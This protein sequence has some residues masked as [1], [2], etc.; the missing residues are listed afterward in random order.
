MITNR[1]KS[2]LSKNKTPEELKEHYDSI[3]LEKG[4]F[5]AMVIAAFIT[6]L[7]VLIIAGVV[8]YGLIWLFVMR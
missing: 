3:E 5:L 1:L 2:L 4:D 6:F 7:P 8:V